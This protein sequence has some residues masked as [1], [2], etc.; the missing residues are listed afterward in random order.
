MWDIDN[1]ERLYTIEE[2]GAPIRF[3]AN[4]HL[5]VAPVGPDRN[6]IKIWDLKVADWNGSSPCLLTAPPVEQAPV[7]ESAFRSPGRS[8]PSAGRAPWSTPSSAF[9]L[10]RRLA[11]A[12]VCDETHEPS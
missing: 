5:L 1:G 8:Q 7:P 11:R 4:S 6:L 9:I 3:L 2:V 12:E 10:A